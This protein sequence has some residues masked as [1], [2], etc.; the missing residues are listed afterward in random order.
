MG[1]VARRCVGSAARCQASA[2]PAVPRPVQHD[3]LLGVTTPSPQPSSRAPHTSAAA[4]SSAACCPPALL[5]SSPASA[6]LPHLLKPARPLE[7]ELNQQPAPVALAV[8]GG[9]PAVS[10][11]GR[12]RCLP[13]CLQFG[14]CVEVTSPSSHR[15]HLPVTS[16]TSVP[17]VCWKS[18]PPIRSARI[19]Q[20]ASGFA[21]SVSDA[22]C[23][24]PR[25]SAHPSLV[26][27]R[28]RRQDLFLRL[29]VDF[30]GWADVLLN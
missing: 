9:S 15:S 30:S 20:F 25:T 24:C 18:Y 10:P 4:P 12:R 13:A 16:R 22:A 17:S 7:V 14:R 3:V 5:Q 21:C 1:A 27:L 29:T 23:R 2:D 11:R 8:S 6:D 28:H 26:R 19:F